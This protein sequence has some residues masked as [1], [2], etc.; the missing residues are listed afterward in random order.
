MAAKRNYRIDFDPAKHEGLQIKARELGIPA[1]D[2]IQASID[3]VD[4]SQSYDP[5]F[6][7]QFRFRFKKCLLVD[8]ADFLRMSEH[9]DPYGSD[10]LG[11]EVITRLLDFVEKAL[12]DND[13]K[14]QRWVKRFRTLYDCCLRDV[15]C[16][17]FFE[18]EP[19]VRD[20]VM[21]KLKRSSPN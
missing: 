1:K 6:L 18:G 8:P 14:N 19:E 16:E 10:K 4:Q 7:E 12:K 21:D 13:P 5:E 2:V 17:A 20:S 15:G 3:V 9:R 11:S